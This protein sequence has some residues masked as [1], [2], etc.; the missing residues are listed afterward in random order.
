MSFA[1]FDERFKSTEDDRGVVR[2][3]HLFVGEYN[4]WKVRDQKPLA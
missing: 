3:G 1:S 2:F 4:Q